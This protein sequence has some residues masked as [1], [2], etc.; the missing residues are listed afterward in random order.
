MPW[1]IWI[2]IMLLVPML[3]GVH[4]WFEIHQ[5][6]AD[7]PAAAPRSIPSDSHS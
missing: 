3:A 5:Q 2:A 4:V 6:P 1:L 7:T